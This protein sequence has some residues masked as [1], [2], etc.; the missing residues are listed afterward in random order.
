MSP[1]V[2]DIMN[3]AV[4]GLFTLIILPSIPLCW[5]I[6]KAYGDAKIAQIADMKVKAAVEFAFER[7]DHIV[8]NTVAAIA[9]VNTKN[10]GLTKEEGKA[11]R[12]KAFNYIKAHLT[13]EDAAVLKTAVKD[14]DK[15]LLTKIEATRF[16]QKNDVCK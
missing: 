14:F 3:Q 10:T 11:R 7:L 4:I 5:K 13:D 16:F 15:Y 9:Q 1:E 12:D 8:T 2:K 6:L